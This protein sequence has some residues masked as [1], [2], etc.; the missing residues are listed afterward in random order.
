MLLMDDTIFALSTAVPPKEGSG[1]AIVRLSGPD[2]FAIAGKLCSPQRDPQ[3]I[4]DHQFILTKIV[5]KN[6]I[7]DQGGLL[8]F[9][10]PHS[11]TGEDV[12][13]FHC[14]GGLILIRALER[15]LAESGA[16]P[17]EPGEFTRRAF[18]NGRMDLIQAES[19]A[20]LISASGEAARREAARQRAGFLS[21]KINEFRSSLRD[22][23]GAIEVDFDYPEEKC[24]DI[25][26]EE[27]SEKLAKLIAQIRPLVASYRTG[28]LLRGIRLA[29]IGRPNV[30]KSSLLN[31]LLNEDRAIVTP[32]PGT[33]RDV[34]SGTLS[35]GGIPVTLLD[36]A[37]IRA[38]P[39]DVDTAEAEGIR[40]SWQEVDRAH[41]VLLVVDLSMPFSK[42]DTELINKTL[43]RIMDSGTPVILVCNKIDLPS[44]GPPEVAG[45]LL[46]A[47]DLPYEAVSALTGKGLEHLRQTILKSLNLTVNPE[48][49]LLTETRHRALLEEV[50]Q[51]LE[52]VGTDLKEGVPLDI[53]ATQL[54]SADRA[55]GRLLGENLGMADLD[56]IFSRFCIG[57]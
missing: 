11:Y 22:L 5:Y 8:G 30:G 1:I 53:A 18:I 48:E 36:T 28:Q 44:A 25:S 52:K 6:D 12:V 16:R 40:R 56:E 50:M 21:R 24:E 49:I 57:K 26:P 32:H 41:L 38:V 13:E 31:A 34:V 47:P 46:G 3:S 4:P 37:G 45:T 55:L 19:I 43:S 7:L 2:A 9:R 27:T 54:W 14:H 39:D 23:L 29:I 10:A 42:E 20:A 33:T 51:I 15:A 35:I 17:A